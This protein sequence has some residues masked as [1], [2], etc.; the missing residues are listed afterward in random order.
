MNRG[1]Q[2]TTVLMSSLVDIERIVAMNMNDVKDIS[3]ASVS[4]R[5]SNVT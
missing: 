5:T 2:K 4:T 1:N 3:R